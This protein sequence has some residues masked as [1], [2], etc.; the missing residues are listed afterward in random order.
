MLMRVLATALAVHIFLQSD[1]ARVS[2]VY[3]NVPVLKVGLK[4]LLS[5]MF[6]EVMPNACVY[7][8]WC[9]AVLM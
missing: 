2:C 1:S 3:S 5:S 6:G 7:E 4:L 9:L 8:T